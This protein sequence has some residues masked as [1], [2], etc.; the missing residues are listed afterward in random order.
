MTG[1]KPAQVLDF[2]RNF[3]TL[4]AM[5]ISVPDL[6][7]KLDLAPEAIL[8][9]A[10][11]LDF[12]IPEDE[13]IP[14]DVAKQIEEIEIGSDIAQTEHAIEEQLEREIVEKQQA[15]TAGSKKKVQKKQ[16]EKKKEELEKREEVII[17]TSDDG[18]IILPEEMTVRELAVKISKPIPLVL[19]KMKQNGIIANL[20]ENIDYETA[21]IIAGEMGVKVKKEAAEL[22][23]EDLFRGD[24]RT[25]LADEETDQLVKRP[26]VISIMGHVDHGKTSILDHIRKANVV[27]GEAGG[28]T[29]SIG[30]YQVEVEKQLI[31]FLDTPGHEAF[32]MMRARGAHA[33]DIAI[34]VVA[35]T[36]S[37][38]PQTIEAINH[39][40]AAGIPIVVAINKMDLPGA[41]PDIV[42]K[43]LAD[44]DVQAD[45][46]GGDVPCIPVSAKTGEGIDKLLD[47]VLTVA[48]MQELKANPNRSA[49]CTVI[50]AEMNPKSGM[51]ATVLVNTGT[52]KQ[53][54]AFVIHDQHGK[55]RIMKNFRGET[56]KVA[57]PST[58]VEITGL[59]KL[60]QMGDLLQVMKSDKE[61]RKKAEAVAGIKHED[62]LL[63]RKKSSLATL[64]ARIAE[65]KVSHLKIVV[66]ADSN[67]TLEAVVEELKKLKTEESAAQI[68]HSGVGE[69]SESDIMLA[70]AGDAL[71]VGF[72]VDASGRLTKLAEREGVQLF[73][74][75][76]IYH[77]T[78]KMQEILEGREDEADLEKI[79]GEMTL[80]GVF[81]T[82]KKMAIAGGEVTSGQVRGKISFRLFRGKEEEPIGTGTVASVQLGQ[83]IVEEVNEGAECGLKLK[84]HDLTF[85]IGDRLQ[86]FT[87]GGDSK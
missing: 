85:E 60:P 61:A 47:T 73:S 13:I 23:S 51:K 7:K 35:A 26:P 82:D 11:D 54:D 41:N 70:S 8:L 76:V 71:V 14:D 68:I 83:K 18:T 65:G 81:A 37:V 38:K 27:D 20:K 74:Y 25:L 50:E 77:L 39:A 56:V 31:T 79:I 21:A 12:D 32:T 84:H 80:K 15:Q 52:L 75:D 30:A 44:H 87:G 67:G 72:N 16:A 64:K 66:K 1:Q 34:L 22:S 42:K 24:L 19:V 53:G 3:D 57:T 55:I 6:A 63:K 62:A 4:P 49:I 58:P 46:W 36:E 17:K 29:Q 10:M 9:H 86:F 28:I 78:E 43:A 48:E 33:T 5:P 2:I 40:H 45:D 59:S 69:I